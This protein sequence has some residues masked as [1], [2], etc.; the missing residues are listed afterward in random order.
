[1]AST[2]RENLSAPT[3]S[4]RCYKLHVTRSIKLNTK[5][6]IGNTILKH[7]FYFFI[8]ITLHVMLSP[9]GRANGYLLD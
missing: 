1:M 2:F 9:E 8:S 3:E 4:N 6:M 7:Q 5:M